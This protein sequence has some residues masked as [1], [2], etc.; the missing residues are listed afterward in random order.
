MFARHNGGSGGRTNRMS[1][2]GLRKTKTHIG[3]TV[4]IG[5]FVEGTAI[6][7]EVFPP[8]IVHQ[9]KKNIGTAD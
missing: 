9:N 3:Q 2:I 5:S 6:T 7:T 1:G 4:Y 8:Q